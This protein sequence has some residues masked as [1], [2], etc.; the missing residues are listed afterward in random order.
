MA[1]LVLDDI[2]LAS[3]L[4][5][6]HFFQLKVKLNEKFASALTEEESSPSYGLK[7]KVDLIALLNRVQTLTGA[8]LT[9]EAQASLA[10]EPL[11]FEVS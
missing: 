3:F 4:R 8:A 10:Q 7:G 11:H 9:S 2:R 1:W 5:E 6:P